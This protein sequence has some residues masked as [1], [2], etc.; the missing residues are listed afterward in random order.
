M[1]VQLQPTSQPPAKRLARGAYWRLLAAVFR[2]GKV[3]FSKL[4]A[5]MRPRAPWP[6]HEVQWESLEA[7]G[8]WL[9]THARWK[10]DRLRGLI[11]VFPTRETLAAQFRAKGY[12][13]DDCDGLAY[14]SAQN[15]IPFADDPN[16]ITIV[17]V[18]LDPYTFSRQPLLYAAHV[19][20][21]F[22]H[23]GAW[24]VISNNVLYPDAYDS[25]AEAVQHNPYCRGHPV[26]WAEARDKD[27]H[28]YASD[29]DLLALEARLE[30]VWRKKQELP[31]IT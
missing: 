27:L 19:I 10:P 5:R 2:W 6:G 12:V 25:F 16:K 31:F 7:Y 20:L 29:A 24:R 1:P 15:V 14:F 23:E 3:P 21:L 9:R 26:L 18:V 13:E 4:I 30:E 17:T 22:P 28:L 11:D 8:Q